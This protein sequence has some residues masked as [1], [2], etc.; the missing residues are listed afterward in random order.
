MVDELLLIVEVL[1]AVVV[2]K[3]I[4]KEVLVVVIINGVI[5]NVGSALAAV[6][7]LK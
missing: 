5:S 2:V 6:A 1:V 3:I 7:G 4:G